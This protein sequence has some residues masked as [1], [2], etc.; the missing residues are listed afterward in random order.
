MTR[1]TARAATKLV[2]IWPV[3]GKDQY[4]GISYGS[5]YTEKVTFE[6]GSTRQ[7]NDAMGNKFIPKSIYWFE[8]SV[9]GLPSLNAP[10]ALGD[11]LSQQDP[12]SV[13]G[14][15]FIRVSKLQDGGRQTD[16]VMVLT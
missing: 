1:P 5:P 10:I 9:N 4:T 3:V 12:T 8:I 14:V 15:E 7:Y 2:T 11:H 6:Q 13:I 16:D